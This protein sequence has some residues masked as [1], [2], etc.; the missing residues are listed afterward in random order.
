M[1]FMGGSRKTLAG[2]ASLRQVN[3]TQLVCCSSLRE[4]RGSLDLI[5]AGKQ[6]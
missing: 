1:G 3:T 6:G 5:G 2:S 4:M